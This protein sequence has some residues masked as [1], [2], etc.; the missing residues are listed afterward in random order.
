MSAQELV[1]I[2]GELEDQMSTAACGRG[3]G[4]GLT[5]T[6]VTQFAAETE[7]RNCSDDSIT[8][9]CARESL[10]KRKGGKGA[11]IRGMCGVMA[12]VAIPEDASRFR[13]R[14]QSR[15]R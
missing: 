1:A 14:S 12:A 10:T 13:H 2:E 7:R 15:P 9:A 11:C 8:T 3:C 5:M 4:S 6:Q